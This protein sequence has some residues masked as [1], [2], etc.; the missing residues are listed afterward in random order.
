MTTSRRPGG[1]R[2]ITA[3]TAAAVALALLLC[4]AVGG[5]TAQSISCG[6]GQCCGTA[7]SSCRPCD[8]GTFKGNTSTLACESCPAGTSAP[9][10]GSLACTGCAPGTFAAGTGSATCTACPVGSFAEGA[11]ATACAACPTDR[12]TLSAGRAQASECV[13]KDGTVEPASPSSSTTLPACVPCPDN[14]V[15][16]S[17]EVQPA[18]GFWSSAADPTLVQR[19]APASACT[20]GGACEAGYD[21]E[22]RLCSD[23]APGHFKQFRIDTCTGC[24]FAGWGWVLVALTPL[25][26]LIVSL[27]VLVHARFPTMASVYITVTVLQVAALNGDFDVDWPRAMP[28][29]FTVFSAF[30]LNQDLFGFQCEV[31]YAGRYAIDLLLPVFLT[32]LYVLL[33]ALARALAPARRMFYVPRELPGKLWEHFLHSWLMLALLSFVFLTANFLVVVDC[34]RGELGEQFLDQNP[35]I[36]CGS[37]EWVTLAVPGL[38]AFVAYVIAPVSVC[39]S[40]LF[41]LRR[42]EPADRNAVRYGFLFA[43]FRDKFYYWEAVNMAFKF[44]CVLLVKLA[45]STPT[46]TVA[47]CATLSLVLA[48]LH[49]WLRPYRSRMDNNYA[50]FAYC[51]LAYLFATV[52]VFD[53]G[54][55]GAD[56]GQIVTALAACVI[57]AVIVGG[58]AVTVIQA[59]ILARLVDPANDSRFHTARKA[60]RK[61]ARRR[62]RRRSLASVGI[63]DNTAAATNDSSASASASQA[64]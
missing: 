31:S 8:R 29:V 39:L 11:N 61:R 1:E 21:P 59:R 64:M 22:S 9:A 56:A 26:L 38:L 52:I 18:P 40:Y 58:T 43:R 20:G 24:P 63:A 30:N 60:E 48:V 35:D 33:Y 12:T 41:K 51:A 55:F 5:A 13:C 36:R 32:V 50:V 3:A 6:P 42:V 34:S 62:R 23:C 54:G 47:I 37:S 19:C 4:G 28:F 17:G 10:Y 44:A 14:A 46:A 25:V 57:V 15:C 2:P 45:S 7:L 53:Q 49:G 27:L 16:V